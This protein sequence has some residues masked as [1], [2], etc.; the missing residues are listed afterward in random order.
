VV[1][2]VLVKERRAEITS[3]QG[4]LFLQALD[5]FAI[6]ISPPRAEQTLLYVFKI[7][8]RGFN[9]SA[10]RDRSAAVSV[11][12]DGRSSTSWRRSGRR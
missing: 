7:T 9:E 4:R 12:T 2:A 1:N 5:S 8:F 11:G 3:A 6:E 10:D